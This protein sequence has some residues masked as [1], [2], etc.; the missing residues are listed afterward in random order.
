MKIDRKK[1]FISK[2][3]ATKKKTKKTKK[4]T[5]FKNEVE[6]NKKIEVNFPFYIIFFFK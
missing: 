6:K 2:W 1:E 4:K 5:L 3:I